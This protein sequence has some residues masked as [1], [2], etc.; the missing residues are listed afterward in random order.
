MNYGKRT[1]EIVDNVSF[2]LRWINKSNTR[3]RGYA[4]RAFF[5]I[6]YSVSSDT[7]NRYVFLDLLSQ[8]LL[9]LIIKKINYK[10]KLDLIKITRT[11][12]YAYMYMDTNKYEGFVLSLDVM[13]KHQGEERK[14]RLWI[15][16]DDLFH[17][18][19]AKLDYISKCGQLDEKLKDV[20]TA[21]HYITEENDLVYWRWANSDE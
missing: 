15:T 17:R 8:D 2:V 13:Y 6:H 10:H 7:N 3:I 11:N 19:L 12:N 18:L 20:I 4:L 9:H 16:R 5:K 14:E 1:Y 21:N